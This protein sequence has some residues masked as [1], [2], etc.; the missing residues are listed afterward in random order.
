MP[1]KQQFETNNS[2]T[3]LKLIAMKNSKYDGNGSGNE[4]LIKNNNHSQLGP[5]K[6]NT[7]I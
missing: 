3:K 7:K 5:K 1:Y 6:I 2:P 4:I